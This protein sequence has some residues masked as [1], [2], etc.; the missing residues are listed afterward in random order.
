MIS[1][2]VLAVGFLAVQVGILSNFMDLVAVSLMLLPVSFI[3]FFLLVRRYLSVRIQRIYQLI[4]DYT[5]ME[6][7]SQVML[8]DILS[9]VE[10]KSEEWNREQ[11]EEIL[12]LKEQAQFRREFLGNVAHELKTPVFSIQGYILTL[13]DGG[14]EDE[15]VNRK[16][17]ERASKATERMTHI[18]EDLDQ[19]TKM[20]VNTIELDK[21]TFDIVD[22]VRDLFEDLEIKANKNGIQLQFAKEYDP[23]FIHADRS[24]ISQVFVNLLNNSIAYGNPGGTTTV[25]LNKVDDR[26]VIEVSDTGLGIDK[27][28]IPRL[29]ERFYR[30]EKSRN[31]HEGGSG[32]GL[33]IVKHIIS[34]H[35][36]TIRVKSKLGE[37]STFTFSLDRGKV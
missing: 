8:D 12:R 30:V 35:G 33:A 11:T 20:E 4:G 6:N 25:S 14:L 32:L 5:E 1:L 37:G 31:R 36:H 15:N 18:L 3:T 28:H 27:E 29:F 22:L 21:S 17:L 26:I 19:L 16:F 23:T 2:I 9:K 10:S 24:K 13:L 34:N 7:E